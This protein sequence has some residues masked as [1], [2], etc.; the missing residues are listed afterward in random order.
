MGHKRPVQ[1]LAFSRDGNGWHREVAT[2]LCC[3]GTLL[4]VHRNR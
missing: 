3:D 2:K 1:A 4:M